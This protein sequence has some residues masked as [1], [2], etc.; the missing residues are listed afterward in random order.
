MS[1]LFPMAVPVHYPAGLV[2]QTPVSLF[3]AHD[4]QSKAQQSLQLLDHDEVQSGPT[5]VKSYTVAFA[6]DYITTKEPEDHDLKALEKA[7]RSTRSGLRARAKTPP[8]RLFNH[9]IARAVRSP[10]HPFRQSS[11]AL[12]QKMKDAKAAEDELHEQAEQAKQCRQAKRRDPFDQSS[13]TDYSIYDPLL[14]KLA[15]QEAEADAADAAAAALLAEQ[16]EENGWDS[17]DEWLAQT[18]AQND[19]EALLES[20]EEE[21]ESESE[22]E[23]E[24]EV[25]IED[26]PSGPFAV[27]VGEAI[28]G[29]SE[30]KESEVESPEEVPELS[31]GRRSQD[32]TE[33]ENEEEDRYVD[34]EDMA[35]CITAD[36]VSH[37]CDQEK[38]GVQLSYDRFHDR[39]EWW[40]VNGFICDGVEGSGYWAGVYLNVKEENM[41][42]DWD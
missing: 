31:E 22:A 11:F 18:T 17:H 8:K 24:D 19:A 42:F 1:L 26:I 23:S 6:N 38:A 33:S 28:S 29:L 32:E 40:T 16:V 3:E 12:S 36:I 4:L 34:L 7:L 27:R 2:Q 39:I 35:T 15:A 9:K 30:E 14:A 10:V 41:D 20:S 25:D 21:E 37:M 13:E 5:S